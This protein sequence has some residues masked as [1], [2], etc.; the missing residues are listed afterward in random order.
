MAH[1]R[2]TLVASAEESIPFER[3]DSSSDDSKDI[4]RALQRRRYR[5][6]YAVSSGLILSIFLNMYL[7]L[8]LAAHDGFSHAPYC[9]R[10]I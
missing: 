8:S 6:M 9:K 7:L 10:P 4:K 1:P 3:L 5:R 2:Y